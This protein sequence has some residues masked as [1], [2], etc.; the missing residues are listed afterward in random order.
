[1]FTRVRLLSLSTYT[2][3]SIQSQLSPIRTRRSLKDITEC[4]VLYL[5]SMEC[6]RFEQGFFL[7]I[8]L[9]LNVRNN[10]A[11]TRNKNV[12][13]LTSLN[14]PGTFHCGVHKGV[15]QFSNT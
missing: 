10:S 15:V 14:K 5:Q 8:I 1:M 13:H 7:R 2:E 9:G 3:L 12:V 6:V 4:I 11:C